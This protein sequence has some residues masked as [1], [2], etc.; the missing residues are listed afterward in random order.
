[1]INS[2][3]RR[4]SMHKDTVDHESPMQHT[5]TKDTVAHIGRGGPRMVDMGRTDDQVMRYAKTLLDMVEYAQK[6][7]L[8]ISWA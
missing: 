1:M 5:G 6:H 4:S 8:I 7:N 2:E 3:G